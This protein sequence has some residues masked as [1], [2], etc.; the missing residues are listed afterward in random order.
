M[1]ALPILFWIGEMASARK[2]VAV[3][4]VLVEPE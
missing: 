3:S 2:L 1:S 4:V